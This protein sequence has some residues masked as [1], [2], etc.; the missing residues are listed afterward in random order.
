MLTSDIMRSMWPHGDANAPG[1]L[2]GI[3]AAAPTVFANYALGSDLLVAHA[4]AQFS[5][6]CGAG[7]E[8][9]ENLNYS[10]QGLMNTWPSRF[11]AAKA[12]DFAR[13]PERIA[14][15]VY[16]GRM[17][18]A[19]GS[20][21][22]WT[23]RGRGGSQ[24]TGRENYTKLGQALGLDLVGN[25]DLV[26]DPQQFLLCAVADFIQCGCLP[27][28]ASDDVSGVTYHLNGGYI[29]LADR[30]SWLAKWKD[31]LGVNGAVP[32]GTLWVQQSLNQL[33]NEPPLATDG[34]YGPS[35][36]AA[37]Q[38]FQ[39]AHGLTTDGKIGPETIAAIEAALPGNG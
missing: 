27:F 32:H 22:G 23:F 24:L 1:L 39:A 11:D 19:P 18:N 8:L 12:A 38:S 15:E 26:N 37:V 21:D 5:V 30:T 16:N 9:V 4:L 29:G 33:G 14:N 36:A 10:E 35:T 31:A 20:D 6:E 28:A 7:G 13:Q 2:D 3:I 34:S 25:P 17:G